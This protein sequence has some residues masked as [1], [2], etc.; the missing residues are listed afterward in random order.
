MNKIDELEHRE[1]LNKRNR[2]LL[3]CTYCE[4]KCDTQVLFPEEI[5]SA[6]FAYVYEEVEKFWL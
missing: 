1:L 5:E 3:F 2:V 6:V 4:N